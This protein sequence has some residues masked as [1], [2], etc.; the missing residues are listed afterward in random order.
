MTNILKIE[1]SMRH[2]GSVTR[3]LAGKVID[4]L[5]AQDPGGK[6]FSRDLTDTIPQIDEA[7]IG[8]NFTDPAER[9]DAQ[10][11]ALS[12]SDTLVEELRAADVIV[13]AVPIYNFGVPAAFKAWVD[14][15][16]RA[17][18]TFRYTED[19]A[20]GLLEGKRA[21]I[22]T[23]SGGVEIDSAADFATPYIRFV[24]G[25]VG[26]TDVTTVSAAQL[27]VE[28]EEAIKKAAAQIDALA[29]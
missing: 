5:L 8:A 28:G 29:A 18:E 19:G 27:M 13:V 25:F 3:D 14:Q 7:W 17:R 20:I 26:I 15:I 11:A 21:I 24:L 10:R 9:N 6:V 16:A 1:A 2:D 4:Q 23:A 22:V 12:L